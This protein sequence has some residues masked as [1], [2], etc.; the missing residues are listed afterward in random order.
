MNA[1]YEYASDSA[2]ARELYEEAYWYDLNA[3]LDKNEPKKIERMGD[4][5]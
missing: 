3:W 5:T 1:V 4:D 2:E